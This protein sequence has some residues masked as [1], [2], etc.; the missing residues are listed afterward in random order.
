MKKDAFEFSRA[1]DKCQ[2]YA[3]YYNSPVAPLTS[4]MSPWPIVMWGIDLIG[5][6]PKAKGGVKYAVVAVDYFT[7]WTEAEPLATITAKKLREFVHRTIAKLEEK[8]GT[9]PE[10]LAQV[11]WSYNT[12]PRTITGETPFSL[13]YGCEAMVPVEVGASSFWRDN[14]SEANEVN[15]LFGHDRRNSGRCS[16][17]DSSISAEDS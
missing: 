7:K 3:D 15:P 6:L 10:E 4:L 13:V 9:W 1:S 16:D 14:D 2:R 5:E 17:Q 8:K 11:L 12:T